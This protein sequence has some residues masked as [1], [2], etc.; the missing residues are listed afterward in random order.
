[1]RP[2]ETEPIGF[3]SGFGLFA[4]GPI[5]R[6]FLMRRRREERKREVAG[7]RRGGRRRRGSSFKKVEKRE[8]RRTDRKGKR[9]STWGERTGKIKRKRVAARGVR[10]EGKK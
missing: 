2:T 3:G 7:R 4:V 6:N 8:G 5:F 10:G 1:M 9:G